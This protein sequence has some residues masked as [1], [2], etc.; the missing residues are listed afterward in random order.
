MTTTSHRYHSEFARRY[1]DQGEAKGEADALLTILDARG[2]Q[3]P[4]H[5]R[6]DIAGCTDLEQL[7]TWIRQASTA[8]KIHELDSPAHW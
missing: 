3:V 7:R 2:V 5:I 8:D 1:Y 6:A 4:D